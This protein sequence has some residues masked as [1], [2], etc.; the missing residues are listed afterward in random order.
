MCTREEG[1]G[2]DL[3]R[4]L[5]AQKRKGNRDIQEGHK[6]TRKAAIGRVPGVP[7]PVLPS[8]FVKQ[9]WGAREGFMHT[10]MSGVGAPR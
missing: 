4:L 2:T 9:C 3:E 5:H 7:V 10:V 8:N 1:R 6:E